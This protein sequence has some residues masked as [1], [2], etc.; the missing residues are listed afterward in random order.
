MSV[1]NI[2]SLPIPIPLELISKI[3][4]AICTKYTWNKRDST[5]K[6]FLKHL[7][8]FADYEE[9]SLAN[10]AASS[11]T[12]TKNFDYSSIAEFDWRKVPELN[13]RFQNIPFI[14]HV[15]EDNITNVVIKSGYVDCPLKEIIPDMMNM[16]QYLGIVRVYVIGKL[17]IPCWTD[18]I[19]HLEIN[20]LCV[21][22]YLDENRIPFPKY[23]QGMVD[24]SKFEGSY[25]NWL[26]PTLTTLISACLELRNLPPN[27]KNYT[28]TG[29]STYSVFAEA[30]YLPIGLEKM[31]YSNIC[32]EL[33]I[34]EITMP[35]GTQYLELGLDRILTRYLMFKNVQK[36]NITTFALNMTIH[37]EPTLSHNLILEYESHCCISCNLYRQHVE[38]ILEE[39]L[40]H[41]NINLI[42]DRH[43][44]PESSIELLECIKQIPSSLK[45]LSILVNYTNIPEFLREPIQPKK[46]ILFDDT[47]NFRDFILQF[48]K[49]DYDTLTEKE[50]ILQDFIRRF[51]HIKVYFELNELPS[52]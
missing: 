9:I 33:S 42:I 27:L 21:M 40:T 7:T 12:H 22:R 3:V 11:I 39:G 8:S 43:N 4:R 19:V 24:K 36:L 47:T 52:G 10:L 18:N 30:E 28:Y 31:I 46:K 34:S 26:P 17:I 6:T 16:L 44:V 14:I 41:L 48:F 13:Q 37:K 38:V 5:Y 2:D 35:P 50:K 32:G 1:A 49:I 45:E 15:G 23:L 29:H 20:N 25:T 51:S